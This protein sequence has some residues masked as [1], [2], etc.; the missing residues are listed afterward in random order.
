MEQIAI[1][2][3]SSSLEVNGRS[4]SLGK[5]VSAAAYCREAGVYLALLPASEP[6]A[7]EEVVGLSQDGAILFRLSLPEGWQFYYFASHINYPLAMVCISSSE[8]FDWYWG[9]EPKQG[10]LISLNRAY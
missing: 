10:R 2:K 7:T 1:E 6:L 9:I 5:E 3:G 8:R 4:I